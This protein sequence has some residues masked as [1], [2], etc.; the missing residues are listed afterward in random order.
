MLIDNYPAGES[1]IKY[2]HLK[3][4]MTPGLTDAVADVGSVAVT[5]ENSKFSGDKY[6]GVDFDYGAAI[7]AFSNNVVSTG[8]RYAMRVS[9]AYLPVIGTTNVFEN[10]EEVFLRGASL[11]DQPNTVWQNLGVPYYIETSVSIGNDNG[12]AS[13]IV[14]PGTTV[15]MKANTRITRGRIQSGLRFDESDRHADGKDH[16]HTGTRDGYG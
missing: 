12:T 5:I 13:L 14:E 10:G 15:R 2:A 11:V 8:T 1:V 4:A 7:T 3:D 9:M 6:Y 16:L